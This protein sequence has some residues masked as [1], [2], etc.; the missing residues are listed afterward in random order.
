MHSP[1]VVKLPSITKCGTC[2]IV[3]VVNLLFDLDNVIISLQPHALPWHAMLRAGLA[4]DAQRHDKE[5]K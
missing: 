3:D 4:K 2:L 5:P 1:M